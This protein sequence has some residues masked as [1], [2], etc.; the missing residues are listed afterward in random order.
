MKTDLQ[1]PEY[2][3]P[4]PEPAITVSGGYGLFAKKQLLVSVSGGETSMYMAW[5]LWTFKRDEF[6]MIFVFS[7]TGQE[8]EQTLEFVK[9]FQEH[10]K[11]P[12]VWIEAV[13]Y[14]QFGKGNGFK[15]VDFD[16]A[17]RNGS[18]FTEVIK[19]HGIPNQSSPHCSKELKGVPIKAYAR[20]IGWKKYY[21]AIGIRPDEADRM[22]PKYI[23]MRLV[24]PLITM[25][26]MKKPQINL[27][28]KFQPFRLELKGYQGNCKWCWKKGDV[29]LFQ[30]I[31]ENPC[32]FDL[33]ELMEKEYGM[34]VPENRLRLMRERGEEPNLPARFFRRNRSV[35]EVRAESKDFRRQPIDDAVIY[36]YQITLDDVLESV[37]LER[38]DDRVIDHLDLDGESCEPFTQC[39]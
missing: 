39:G 25:K 14:H 36:D 23:K 27:W 38:G 8:N 28:W 11:I 6:E 24:Y 16:S 5:W 33:P 32:A 4:D 29:K 7:N 35:E 26:P 18:V 31:K 15:I 17:E 2:S 13:V 9:R 19:K 37:Q 3:L 21:L 12:I 22:N 30:I 10:F 1:Q 34:F 20:S